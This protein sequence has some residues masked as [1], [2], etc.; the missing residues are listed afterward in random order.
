MNEPGTNRPVATENASAQDWLGSN[1]DPDVLLSVPD[2]GVDKITLSV[3]NLV[4]DIDL[5]AKVLDVVE[6]HVGAHVTL[7][8]VELE[9]ENVRAQAM[10]KVKLDKVA[11]IVDRVMQTLDNNPE[12]ITSLTRPVGEGVR[13]AGMGIREGVREIGHRPGSAEPAEIET[14]HEVDY[15]ERRDPRSRAVDPPGNANIETVHLD[16]QWWNRQEGTH[17][18]TGPHPTKEAAMKEGR[19]QAIETGVEHLIFTMDGR[20]SERHDYGASS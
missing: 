6:L 4:A 1:Q 16:G 10:L 17:T 9:I 12:I 14:V 8:K 13:Q 11:E 15:D 3:E 2:L 19:D 7:G 5:H 20:V 18:S